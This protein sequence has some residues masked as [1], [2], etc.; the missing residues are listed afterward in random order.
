MTDTPKLPD[1]LVRFFGNRRRQEDLAHY[2]DTEW[3]VP[4]DDDRHMFEM[5]TL[6]GAQAGLS[7]EVV[8]RKRAGYRRALHDFDIARVVEMG[9]E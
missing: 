8:L 3:G 2:H 9:D 7:W 5:L 1:G 4:G 6:E